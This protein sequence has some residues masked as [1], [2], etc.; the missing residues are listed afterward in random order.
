MAD[1]YYIEEDYYNPSLGYF[2]YTADAAAASGSSATMSV[3]GDKVVEAAATMSAAFT[4]TADAFRTQTAQSDI[5]SAFAQ[6]ASVGKLLS[7]V[8]DCGALFTP[9]ITA[10]AFKNHTA[11]LDV[12][13]TATTVGVVNRSA[14][15]A[16]DNIANLNAQAAKTVDVNTTSTTSA[17][18]AVNGNFTAA[19]SLVFQ[20]TS[21][22]SV[23][24]QNVQFGQATLAST[25]SIFTTRYFGSSRP[26]SGTVSGAHEFVTSPKQYGTHALKLSSDSS[27]YSSETT[28][29]FIVGDNQ[30]FVAEAWVY[31]DNG[32]EYSGGIQPILFGV[33]QVTA[34]LASVNTASSWAIGHDFTNRYLKFTYV[35]NN[36]VI[37]SIT[38]TQVVAIGQWVH[39]AVARASGVLRLYYN[40]NQVGSSVSF[41]EAFKLPSSAANRKLYLKSSYNLGTK[42]VY[43]DEVSYRIGSSSREGYS[44]VIANEPV[45][46]VILLHLDNNLDDDTSVVLLGAAALTSAFSLT[47][48]AQELSSA[49]ATLVSTLTLSALASVNR[50]AV[51]TV[52]L[53]ATQTVTVTRIQEAVGTLSTQFNQAVTVDKT[54]GTGASFNLVTSVASEA[55]RTR[56]ATSTITSAFTPTL[57]ADVFKNMTAILDAVT[58]LTA[59]ATTNVDSASALLSAFALASDVNRTRTGASTANSSASLAATVFRTQDNQAEFT[60]NLTVNATIGLLETAAANATSFVSMGI[61][62]AKTATGLVSAQTAFVAQAVAARTRSTPVQL[63]S[64]I[65]QT[66]LAFKI[67]QAQASAT[68]TSQVSTAA[69][70]T[71]VATLNINTAATLGAQVNKQVNPT[72][73]FESIGTQLAVPHI[74]AEGTV[75]LNAASAL[76]AVAGRL[77]QLATTL[78]DSGIRFNTNTTTD[79]GD[80]VL[81]LADYSATPAAP[82]PNRTARYAVAFWAHS[83]LGTVFTHGPVPNQEDGK[84][85]FGASSLTLHSPTDSGN[86]ARTATF[87]GLNTTGWHH[88]LIYKSTST[89]LP[90]LYQDGVLTA[91]VTI[92]TTDDGNTPPS[93]PTDD[94]LNVYECGPSS[95]S[96]QDNSLNFMLG[97]AV[98]G[99]LVDLNE[100]SNIAKSVIPMQGSLHQF[101][102]YF[103]SATPDFGQLETRQKLFNSGGYRDLGDTG[104]LT[105]LAQPQIY[106]RLN[107][108][109]DTL[110]RGTIAPVLNQTQNQLLEI[111]AFDV[112]P[113]GQSSNLYVQTQE[114]TGSV[115]NTFV[116]GLLALTELTAA[117][118]AVLLLQIDMNSSVLQA[119]AATR[120]RRASSTQAVSTEMAVSG[121]RIAST[122]VNLDTTANLAVTIGRVQPA[123]AVLD[124][125]VSVICEEGELVIGS[126]VMLVNTVLT[127]EATEILA[128]QGSADLAA[129][130]SLNA[131]VTRIQPALITV[132]VT[133]TVTAEGLQ[134]PAEQGSAAL[135][136]TA[137]V[138]VSA[139]KLVRVST[140]LSVSATKSVQAQRLAGV[141]SQITVNS[142]ITATLG[143][144]AG[145]VAT[146]LNV[147]GFQITVALVI[148][149]DPNLTIRI[150]PESRV[151]TITGETRLLMVLSETRL[152]TIKG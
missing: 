114:I 49:Q 62:A 18:V 104:T 136:S 70:K 61:V 92:A 52:N 100:L 34:G 16:V 72:L 112:F 150:L 91:T 17:T 73:V 80:T 38:T 127:C 69:V 71:S 65:T 78:P 45:T 110:L 14:T 139:I 11:I 123:G 1:L 32:V 131:I 106:V 95:F 50:P 3:S 144:I 149:I 20:S 126:A 111:A 94:L 10:L 4:Q 9:G 64:A 41:T 117:A 77:I 66:V 57:T 27:S 5:S 120:Q 130:C 60:V 33:G 89:V 141:A 132:T 63:D 30:D 125:V 6:S 36:D 147:Q 108:G 67:H 151:L 145:L 31:I 48:T 124:S 59:V 148:N 102:C 93:P 88:Y 122:G 109:S 140:A 35:S 2:V 113:S 137:A 76:T 68:V 28:G 54:A 143:K 46:Q 85:T 105:G 26:M 129:A 118:N 15:M 40:N 8:I 37:A 75:V 24:A 23:S 97:A 55:A 87:S 133:A 107:T 44:A 128:E 138:S 56:T 12:V 43:F 79:V 81:Y 19:N 51:L 98:S 96:P 82:A 121:A 42:T 135:T 21:S 90:Q 53:V 25:S 7:A 101:V 119:A 134:I 152:L 83:P 84:F 29:E 146:Q 39:I 103:D 99:W 58:T 116:S 22:L 74:N 115:A 47:A 142:V 13:F 86:D